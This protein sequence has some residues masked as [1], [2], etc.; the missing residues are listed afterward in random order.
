LTF[1][2]LLQHHIECSSESIEGGQLPLVASTYSNDATVA[3]TN[4][5]N[6]N[7]GR[8]NPQIEFFARYQNDKVFTI[9]KTHADAINNVNP[10]TFASGQVGLI[11]DVF[12]NKRRSPMKFDP[13]FTDAVSTTGK[14]YIQCKD[15]V[16]SQPLSVQERTSSGDYINQIIL[17]DQ[18]LLICGISVLKIRG[19]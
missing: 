2:L 13:A 3:V 6:A 17:T 5:Q 15:Q 1:H 12:A 10:I 7:I 4:P 19:S 11:F 16:T 9:H 8:I 18:E 14:W